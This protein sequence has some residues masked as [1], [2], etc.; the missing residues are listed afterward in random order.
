MTDILAEFFLFSGKTLVLV[1]AIGAL[2]LFFTALSLR[3]R[4]IKQN[5]EI[6][7]LN[8]KWNQ[9]K[10]VLC[11][12]TSGDPGQKKA[13]IKKIKAQIKAQKKDKTEKPKIY[14]ID[15]KGD[16]RATQIQHL[17]EEVT[18][19]LS[20]AKPGQDEVVVLIE[21]GGGLVHSYGLAAAQMNRV[22]EAG[23]RL[24]A[25]V[26]KIAASGGYMMACTAD[27]I[28]A[29]PWAVLGSIGVIAQVPNLNR[30]LKKHDVDYEEITAGEFKRTISIL[31]E[32]TPQGR[33]KFGEQIEDTH[34]LFKTFVQAHRPQVNLE[35]VAT[36]EHWLGQR[37]LELRLVDQLK[38]SDDYLF[39]KRESHRIF[40]ISIEAKKKLAEKI[41]EV[42]ATSGQKLIDLLFASRSPL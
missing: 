35:E 18:A 30:L 33:K 4:G 28:V 23:I 2:A 24:T 10:R 29:A 40:K 12:L 16:L 8:D 42:V 17:R 7:C 19:V 3:Q 11:A 9:Y 39:E 25:C 27:H 20:V 32:I 41:S 31:G 1:L 14:V 21:S 22:K 26:D 34:L 13:E 36:G 15:F 38:T 37:A 6:E 5:I